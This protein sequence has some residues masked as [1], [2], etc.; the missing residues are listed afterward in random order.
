[1]ALYVLM[2]I[3]V[4]LVIYLFYA[5]INPRK[6]LIGEITHVIP[7]LAA[8]R[9]G[10]ADRLSAQHSGRPLSRRHR[11]GSED[12]VGF[13]FDPLDEAIYWLIGAAV[14]QPMNW[15][16][17]VFHML[18][19]NLFMAL[20]IYLILVF[21][22][23]LPFNPLKL[24]GM[25]PVLAFNTAI[26]FV[27]NTDWQSYGGE[28]TSVQLQPDGGDHLPDV[29]LGHHR[30]C[31]GD[32]LHSGLHRQGWRRQSR[33]FLSRPGAVHDARSASGQPACSPCS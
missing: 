15:K 12:P 10:I 5:V 32:G 19:T 30:V 3:V 11:H 25:E 17:Y 21:Q 29:H 9:A 14:R 13:G 26:S 18:A 31:R 4:G 1:M 7:V 8:D 23:Y 33:Q 27:T 22:D 6:V 20:L 28:T 16:A 2:A 24:R